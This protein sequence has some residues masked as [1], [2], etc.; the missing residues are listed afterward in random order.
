MSGELVGHK[1]S[2]VGHSVLCVGSGAGE[3]VLDSKEELL[4]SGT[5]S[6]GSSAMSMSSS[7]ISV[8][9]SSSISCTMVVGSKI[10][11]KNH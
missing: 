10:S 7:T 11:D 4:A 9:V 1:H 2:H 5:L 3:T 8:V 6:A